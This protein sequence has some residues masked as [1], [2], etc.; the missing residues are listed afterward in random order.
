MKIMKWLDR[1]I[2]ISGKGLDAT[3]RRS[4]KVINFKS[5]DPTSPA[6]PVPNSTQRGNNEVGKL[7]PYKVPA[8]KQKIEHTSNN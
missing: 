8:A 6:C 7:L 2:L 4:V 3:N 1:V 5:F